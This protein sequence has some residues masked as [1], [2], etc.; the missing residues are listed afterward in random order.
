MGCCSSTKVK[1]WF[2]EL[3]KSSKGL[4]EEGV[5]GGMTGSLLKVILGSY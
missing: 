5:G 1:C 4:G 2:A 3:L